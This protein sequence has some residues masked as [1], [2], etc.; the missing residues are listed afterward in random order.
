M[1]I[2]PSYYYDVDNGGRIPV[3]EPSMEEFRDF[4]RFM[5]AI[6]HYGMQSSIVKIIPPKEWSDNL[7]DITNN[8][9]NVRVRKPIEQHISS[10][11]SQG[12]FTQANIEK[13]R[14]YTVEQWRELCEQSDHRPPPL[15]GEKKPPP[16]HKR[17][18]KSDA[19]DEPCFK[20]E[21]TEAMDHPVKE[22]T[23]HFDPIKDAISSSMV[24]QQDKSQATLT[25]PSETAGD[26][27]F[28]KSLVK[29]VVVNDSSPNGSDLSV[30]RDRMSV[31]TMLNP[32]TPPPSEL[33][34]EDTVK[35]VKPPRRRDEGPTAKSAT[36]YSF[37]KLDSHYD[38]EYCKSLERYYWR[39]LTFN[40]PLYGADMSGTLFGPDEPREWNMNNLDN[41]LNRI[42][43]NLPGVNTPYLYFGMWK[44]TFAWHVEDMD[45]YSINYLHFGAPKQWYAIPAYHRDKFERLM[46]NTFPQDYQLCSQFLRHKTFI[47]SP[48]FL[49]KSGVDS[50]RLVQH[51]GEFVVTFPRGY[52]AGYNL[53]FNCAES[54]NFALEN[55]VEIGK[56]AQAC[57][58]VG[59]S[60]KID[61]GSLFGEN[62]QVDED[63]YASQ[64]NGMRVNR[65]EF[66]ADDSGEDVD[67][68]DT[69]VVKKMKRKRAKMEE[70]P[71]MARSD[72]KPGVK[73]ALCPNYGEGDVMIPTTD[74]QLVH[75]LCALYIPETYILSTESLSNESLDE[76]RAPNEASTQPAED[77]STPIGVERAC[78]LAD[79]PRARWNLRCL[80]C[81]T[82]KRG[83]CVQCSSARCSKAFHAT[84]AE[85][86]DLW[87]R[88]YTTEDGPVFESF[89]RQHDPR[90]KQEKSKIKSEALEN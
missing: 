68:T 54:V 86:E 25:M 36:E 2:H 42:H 33:H 14:I 89:C 22:E 40:A 50:H 3:F 1:E 87:M 9:Q 80:L 46:Q 53:G 84:C 28:A 17:K 69:G 65:V 30:G 70:L 52:H 57:Q 75:R 4:R 32:S 67:G 74:G 24:Q 37:R 49:A 35:S 15:P 11:G 38:V 85:R 44:A 26:N 81:K 5:S 73:C 48:T 29:V 12:A 8:L 41:I 62:P 77:R 16:K 63:S 27:L 90:K 20:E 18:R 39:N 61:V 7:P 10:A 72:G 31:H 6:T 43:V 47:V 76:V 60:V 79:I 66:L 82:S 56:E 59:D 19:T 83:A 58:C 88:Q 34:V 55:W 45:L 78:G 64:N 13:R 71:S 21:R 51:E 23:H